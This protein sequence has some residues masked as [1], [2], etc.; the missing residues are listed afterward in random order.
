MGT[1]REELDI[2]KL[3]YT[4]SA[5]A[6]IFAVIV[7]ALLSH[8]LSLAAEP[9]PDFDGN[10]IVAIPDFLLFVDVF[11]AK[12]GDEKYELKYDLD[13]NGEIGIPDFLIFVDSFGKTVQLT[14]GTNETGT[15]LMYWTD[16]RTQKIQRADLDGN[17]IEDLITTRLNT[18]FG[19]AL[20]LF[21]GKMYWTD[22]GKDKIQRADLD[23]SNVEDLITTGLNNPSDLALDLFSGKMYWTDSGTDK[24]Q[25]ADLDGSNVEDLITT[26]LNDSRGIALDLFSGKMYWTDSGTDKIQR[27]D[28]DGSNVED[29]IT[30]GLSD[31]RGIALDPSGG[32]MYW[33][34]RGTDKIQRADLDGSNV[35]DLITTGLSDSRGIALDP[36]GG[37]MY[38]VDRGTD[39]I[40]RA[41]LDGNNIED[42]VTIAEDSRLSRIALDLSGRAIIGTVV[43]KPPSK[44]LPPT[45]VVVSSTSLTVT[46]TEPENTEPPITDYNVRYKERDG[47]FVSWFH[48]G[49][50]LTTTITDLKPNTTYEVQVRAINDEGIGEW[51]DS[52][53]E[54]T[55]IALGICTRTTQVQ[56]A[57]LSLIDGVGNCAMVT[58][59][60]L[61]RITDFLDLRSQRISALQV[62]DF[63]GLSNLKILNLYDNDLTNLPADVF[64]DLPNLKF[65]SLDNNGLT[66]LSGDVF[67]DLPNLKFLSLNSNALSELPVGIFSRLSNL[68]TLGLVDIDKYVENNSGGLTALPDSVFYGLSR[69]S[70]LDLSDN[71]GSPFTLTLVLKRTDTEDLTALSP[72]IVV[73]KVTQGAPFDMRVSLSATGGSLTD[74]EGNTITEVIISKGSI[75]SESVK[76]TQSGITSVILSMD[77]AP[78]PPAGYTGL[79]ISL[80]TSLNLF[81]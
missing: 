43:D 48:T 66:T 33:V 58:A 42:L 21:S 71:T 39:K 62:N 73:I 77:S 47:D 15:K 46:W 1:L 67:S 65:L 32:K 34:D 16:G 49:P 44:P 78:V 5:Y 52:G 9:S 64:S 28:L 50:G 69:L 11:G 12:E 27:A 19:I 4:Y 63:S 75:E 38:W 7:I 8:P 6:Q 55:G 41:D 51:S 18:P 17:I 37:K 70:Y 76:V 24:I 2:S 57:I 80:G 10:G 36:S 59:E 23:G 25:R 3:L 68:Q 13:E 30:T 22:S 45:V 26:G 31:S 53:I 61:T 79:Q 60:D 20:D 14:N 56:T 40:Q 35:E 29:L 81:E 54:A 72:A 74:E